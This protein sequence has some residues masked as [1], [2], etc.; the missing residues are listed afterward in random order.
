MYL[1]MLQE[2]NSTLKS[3]LT[4]AVNSGVRIPS[5]NDRKGGVVGGGEAN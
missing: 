2:Q 1:N 5:A 4:L 3:L